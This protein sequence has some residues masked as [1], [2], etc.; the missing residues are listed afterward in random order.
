MIKRLGRQFQARA[1]PQIIMRDKYKYLA[2]ISG[3]TKRRSFLDDLA[4]VRTKK[5]HRIANAFALNTGRAAALSVALA[6]VAYSIRRDQWCMDYAAYKTGGEVEPPFTVFQPS[7]KLRAEFAI[8]HG[9]WVSLSAEEL[10]PLLAKWGAGTI[11]LM[12][13]SVPGMDVSMEALLSSVVIESWI[14]FE[15]LVSDLW[16]TAVDIGPAILRKKVLAKTLKTNKSGDDPLDLASHEDIEFDPAKRL[17]T[18]YREARRVSFQRL[19]FIIRN[20]EI[21]FGPQIKTL[22]QSDG[23]YI[24]ALSACRNVLIHNAG[25]ADITFIKQVTSF[26][27][28]KDIKPKQKLPL[29]GDLVAKLR[30]ASTS[31]GAKLIHLVDDVLTPTL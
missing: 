7:A 26:D 3:R 25:K 29:N 9:Q 20:Y 6:E 8:Q 21:V 24:T 2:L 1:T 14:A 19:F 5:L 31:L 28:L 23:G 27:E 22:F 30:N 4:T 15:T 12:L 18:A 10:S 16:V 11:N 13:Q 17:G